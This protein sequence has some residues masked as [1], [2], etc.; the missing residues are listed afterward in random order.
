MLYSL[1]SLFILDSDGNRIFSK[2]YSDEW[3]TAVL[4]KQFEKKVFDKTHSDQIDICLIDKSVILYKNNLDV[5]FYVVGSLDENELILGN[6]LELLVESLSEVIKF[7]TFLTIE[8]LLRRK[9]C[10]TIMTFSFFSLM[11]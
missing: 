7:A 2:Y 8:F 9:P 6:I 3:P 10:L 1:K 4:Q 5:F 11:S